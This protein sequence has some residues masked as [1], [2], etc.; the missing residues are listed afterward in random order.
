MDRGLISIKLRHFFVK[1]R[2]AELSATKLRD[3]STKNWVVC[4]FTESLGSFFVKVCGPC[5]NLCKVH[6]LWEMHGS[7][8]VKLPERWLDRGRCRRIA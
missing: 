4:R 6:V 8:I 7:R 2:D 1:N 5:V 3:F